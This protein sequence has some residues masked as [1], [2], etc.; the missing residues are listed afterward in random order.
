MPLPS[1]PPSTLARQ[2]SVS[3]CPS[4]QRHCASSTPA[5]SSSAAS[6]AVST[7]RQHAPFPAPRPRQ[8][9]RQRHTA[10][11][12]QQHVH[13]PGAQNF[14]VVPP[15]R[16]A[17]LRK[18]GWMHRIAPRRPVQQRA[19]EHGTQPDCQHCRAAHAPAAV[20]PVS[21]CAQPAAQ[22]RPRRAEQQQISN[23]RADRQTVDVVQHAYL[24]RAVIGTPCSHRFAPCARR[25]SARP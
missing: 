21:P 19:V 22:R 7:R 5:D 12:E 2:S 15:Q 6:T 4:C 14:R 17:K 16:R 1:K 20:H 18:R 9:L 11:H 13:P 10:R 25:E 8:Q 23:C 3:A 24:S